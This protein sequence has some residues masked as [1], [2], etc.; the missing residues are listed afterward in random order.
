[1]IW[2]VIPSS[3]EGQRGAGQWK[4]LQGIRMIL[5][6]LGSEWREFR[7][8][9]HNLEELMAQLGDTEATVIWYYSFWPEAMEAL[10]SRCPRIR[11]V[12]R[13]VNAEALQHWLRAKK[14][15]RR[16]RGLPRDLYG[17][18]RLLLRDRRCTRAADI[19][20]GISP[21]DDIH[22]W[23]RFAGADK[24][25]TVPYVC[26]WSSLLP[27]VNVLPWEA[28]EETIV[29]LAGSR[30]TIG[31]GHIAG[32]AA[33]ARQ[34]ELSSWHFAA[35]AGLLGGDP[36]LLPDDIERMGCLEEPWTLLCKVK[37]VAVLSPWG[38]GYKTTVPDALTAGCHVLIHPRQ[39]ARL[40]PEEQRL[41][42]P[43]DPESLPD[44]QELSKTLS[45]PPVYKAPA[46]WREQ[47]VRS[48]SAWKG[49]LRI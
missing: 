39:H 6:Q 22:Y 46:I 48:G 44:L 2:L 20:A 32:F 17:F 45:Q 11:L 29:C 16:I 34:R 12:L 23:G 26:P 5:A 37:V 42:I 14:D 4:D 9:E 3:R 10:K 38:Y 27:E 28:R 31:R 41:A 15:W 49:V 43:L 36:D 35:S 19:L 33:L 40:L 1:M 30:D 24:I 13:T 8:D 21:W 25:Q 47:T 7:F 18:S